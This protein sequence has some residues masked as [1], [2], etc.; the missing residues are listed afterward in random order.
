MEEKLLEIK[1]LSVVFCIE[2]KKGNLRPLTS[3]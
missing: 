1:D 2:Y 3:P